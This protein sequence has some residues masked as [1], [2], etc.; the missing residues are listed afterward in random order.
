MKVTETSMSDKCRIA[1]D[2]NTSPETLAVLAT[3]ESASVRCWVA[4]NRNTPVKALK[5]L[6]TDRNH[7]V[8]YNVAYNPNATEEICLMIKAYEK[9]NHL[10]LK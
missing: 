6:A 2:G 10:V 8:R 5:N 4:Y 1:G 9:F 3:D 7:Y